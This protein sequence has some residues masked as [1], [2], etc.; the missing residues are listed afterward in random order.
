MRSIWT[1]SISF[2]LVNIP[3]KLVTAVKEHE[4]EFD[5]LAK[6]DLAPIRYARIAT[7]TGKEIEYKDIVKGYEYTKGKYVV[8]TPEDFQAASP[9]KSKAIDIIQFV[10][11]EEID[12]IYYDKP[13]YLLPGKGAEKPYQLLLKALEKSKTVG[14]AEFMMRNRMHI[15]AI[16]PHG[17]VLMINQMRYETEVLEPPKHEAQSVRITAKEME[18]AS[19]LIHQLTDAF[20]ASKF[21]DTYIEKLKKVI[22]A[23]AAGKKIVTPELKLVKTPAKDLMAELK[24]SLSSGRKKVA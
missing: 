16:R 6:K 20:D 19:K 8:V 22:K 12:S 18:L 3:V 17:S 5:M 4:V 10:K 9:E 11:S 14:I 21:K 7:S 13:Y 1:G 15:S 23:K 2:G 24:E